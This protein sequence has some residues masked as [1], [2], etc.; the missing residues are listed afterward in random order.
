M[1]NGCPVISG[2]IAMGCC[3]IGTTCDA[4]FTDVVAVVVIVV[5]VLAKNII[6]PS[7]KPSLFLLEFWFD[8]DK[9]VV[10]VGAGN[11]SCMVAV[12][13][14]VVDVVKDVD[15]CDAVIVVVVDEEDIDEVGNTFWYR[16]HIID[17]HICRLVNKWDRDSFLSPKAW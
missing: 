3:T 14:V 16:L 1:F 7:V 6:P 15:C 4:P 11:L 13:D 5:V 2:Y 12:F 10:V 9:T 17:F 8:G